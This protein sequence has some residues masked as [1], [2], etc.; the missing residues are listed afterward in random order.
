MPLIVETEQ[1][2]SEMTVLDGGAQELYMEGQTAKK[3]GG[4]TGSGASASKSGMLGEAK[5]PIYFRSRH[6]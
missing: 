3:C 6:E 2:T 1:G 4:L 5:E